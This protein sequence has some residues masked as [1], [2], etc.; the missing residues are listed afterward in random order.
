MNMSYPPVFPQLTWG[1]PLMAPEELG[2]SPKV[3]AVAQAYV[4]AI[5]SAAVMVVYR[6]YLLAAWGDIARCYNCHSI[7]K[8]LL[9]AL[10]GLALEEGR[11]RLEST[12]EE[13][14]IDDSAPALAPEEKQ[15][16]LRD[17][18]QSRSGVY[19]EASYETEWA[20]KARPARGSHAPGTFWYYN[21]WDFNVLGTILEQGIGRSL[22]EEFEQRIAL[23][24][25]MQDFSRQKQSYEYE[26]ISQHPAYVFR[27]SARDLARF[28]LLFLRQGNWPGKPLLAAQWV[29]ACT[30]AY[31]HNEWGDGFG[32]MWWIAS[33]G[34]LFPN[35][36]LEETAYAA[37]GYGGHYLAL[38]P[39]RDLLVVHRA[40]TERPDGTII[41]PGDTGY[42]TSEQSGTLL[43]LLL[44]ACP[45]P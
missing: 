5:G 34:T 30:T 11:L 25:Q 42:V 44:E 38:F 33:S 17:L 28:G 40:D 37:K 19:H 3:L 39:A 7:R 29:Q 27:L 13:L 35:L 20:K 6:G 23:P 8:S 21:N 16:T 36:S 22:F 18:L 9:S 31:S 4:Q 45:R 10:Y 1:A 15:A 24:L 12:L 2:W 14:G 32:Y 26:P 43:A 41:D